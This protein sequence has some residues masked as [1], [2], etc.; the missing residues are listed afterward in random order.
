M[1]VIER[2]SNSPVTLICM[3]DFGKNLRLFKIKKLLSFL[4][5][6]CMQDKLCDSKT[7]N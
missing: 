5:L 6:L 4:H 7:T 2:D 3:W 1:Y